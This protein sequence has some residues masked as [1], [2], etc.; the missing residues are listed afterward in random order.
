MIT[1]WNDL[2]FPLASTMILGCD[3]R[4]VEGTLFSMPVG[5]LDGKCHLES[6]Q[7]NLTSGWLLTS[8]DLT[9]TL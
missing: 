3:V 9:L 2:E 1:I 7:M 6:F 4:V 5:L 8:F